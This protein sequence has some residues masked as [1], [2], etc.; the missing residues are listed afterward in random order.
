MRKLTGLK[1]IDDRRAPEP[2]IAASNDAVDVLLRFG[3]A[4][5][6]SGGTAVR[7]RE[8]LQMLARKLDFD[9]QS[10]NAT[11]EHIAVCVARA[12]ERAMIAR[13]IGPPAINAWRIGELERL[14]SPGDASMPPAEIARRLDEIETAPPHHSTATVAACVG[15]ASGAFAFLNGA[16]APEMVAAAVGGGIGQSIRSFF[17]R[18]Q[19]NPFGTAA[20]SGMIASGAYVLAAALAGRMGFSYSHYQAGFISTVLFL[21][22][23]FPLVAGLFDLV[24]HQTATALSRLAYGTLILLAVASGL[25]IVVSVADVG[26]LRQ[27]SLELAYPPTLVLRA[28]ASF[29]AGCAFAMLFNSTTSTLLIAGVVAMVA[30]SLRLIL[31]DMNMMLAPAAF[32]AAFSLGLVAMFM[33]RRFDVQL[34][35]IV[36]APIVIMIPG[37]YAFETIVLFNRGQMIEALQAFA[38]CGLVICALAL[39]LSAARLASSTKA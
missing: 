24:Q 1:T 9:L 29:I 31:I 37:L 35:A 19:L 18:R 11:P 12:G 4:M 33:N 28:V 21:I 38:A 15:V 39:G 14:A 8:L 34:V 2:A 17:S 10:I 7:T 3:A 26:L 27:P 30:N 25:T 36:A 6:R 5:L 16:A 13:D 20:L 22:P 23:G 32:L